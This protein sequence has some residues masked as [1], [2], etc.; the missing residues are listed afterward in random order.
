MPVYVLCSLFTHPQS[1]SNHHHS[2][3]PALP[4][5]LCQSHECPPGSYR[6]LW[7]RP[8][9]G[10]GRSPIDLRVRPPAHRTSGPTNR[11][12]SRAAHPL[13]CCTT[14]VRLGGEEEEE[15]NVPH[16]LDGI[17][18]NNNC[19]RQWKTDRIDQ[20]TTR[21]SEESHIQESQSYRQSN[22]S[23]RRQSSC[24]PC[25]LIYFRSFVI[26][27]ICALLLDIVSQSGCLSLCPIVCLFVRLSSYK[28]SINPVHF[29]TPSTVLTIAGTSHHFDTQANRPFVLIVRINSNL[30]GKHHWLQHIVHLAVR[31][32]I[33]GQDLQGII[34]IVK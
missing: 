13:E 15:S 28:V 5:Y 23:L 19:S 17:L 4:T 27:C 31:V 1:P 33:A 10:P 32:H 30:G 14:L 12:L 3:L 9:I 8:L 18:N 21:R 16:S 7:R 2:F 29:S 6:F 22:M 20:Q 24:I 25:A 26:C 34:I 11:S